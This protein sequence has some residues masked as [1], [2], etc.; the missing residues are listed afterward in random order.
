VSGDAF[1]PSGNEVD[2]NIRTDIPEHWNAEQA[3]AVF[4]FLDQ[5]CALIWTRYQQ[6]IIEHLGLPVDTE[7]PRQLDLFGP[8]DDLPF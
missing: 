1:S 7:H 4:D 5:L 6:Q 2:M 3:L 8:N